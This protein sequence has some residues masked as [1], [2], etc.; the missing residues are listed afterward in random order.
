M[1]YIDA[2]YLE[3]AEKYDIVPQDLKCENCKQVFTTSVPIRIKGYVGLETPAH[4]CDRKFNAAVFVP[5][6]EEEREF[7]K[8]II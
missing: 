8:G 7:W 1:I 3:F 5:I 4:G 6:S 2:D